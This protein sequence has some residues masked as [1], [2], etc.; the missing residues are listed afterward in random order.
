MKFVPWR[1]IS[2][3]TSLG[4][5]ILAG[6]AVGGI[7]F[8]LAG[9]LPVTAGRVRLAGIKAPVEIRR[10]ADAVPHIRALS[11]A[12]ALLGLGYVHAQDRLW[13]MEYQRRIG[14]GRLAEVLGEAALETDQFLRTVGTGRA[15]KSAWQRTRP[16][17]RRL[18][19]AYTAGINAFIASHRGRRL[20]VEFA[21]LGFEPEPWKPE[22][23]V[24]WSKIMAL[25]LGGNW[26]DEILRSELAARLG[27]ERAARLLPAYTADG[28]VILP[29]KGQNAAAAVPS[30]VPA[31]LRPGSLL[32]LSDKI[33]TLLGGESLAVG[34][35]NWVVAGSRTASGKPMLASDPHLGHQIPSVWYLAHVEGGNFNAIGATL[36]GL[37][38][39]PIGHNGRIAWGV[40]NLEADV[41]D[42]F[43]EQ[44][45]A[46]ERHYRAKGRWQPLTVISEV[47]KVKGKPA[48]PIAVRITRHGPLISD[49]VK[50]TAQ[51][52]A[53]RWAALDLEDHTIE[54][55]LGVN[56]ASDWRDFTRA[57]ANFH[58]PM[59]NFVYAD[60]AGNIGYYAAGAVP[61]RSSGDGTAPVP[62]QDDRY[63]WRGYVPF[64]ALP[65]TYNPPRGFVATA[66]NRAVSGGYPYVLSTNWAPP[67]RA[68]RIVERLAAARKL[69]AR[70]MADLQGDVQ[71]TYVRRLLPLLL[72]VEGS[73]ARSRQAIAFLRGWDGRLTGDSAAAAIFWA[74][75][76]RIPEALF[77]DELGADL[78]GKYLR[79]GGMLGKV[80]PGALAGEGG[81]CDDAATR[82][83]EDCREILK[84]ALAAGLDDMTR[85]QGS[86][87]PAD[88]RWDR[89]HRAVF[90]H[91]P[92]DKI[93]TLKPLFS[94]SIGNGGDSFTVN[95]APVNRKEPYN[96]FVGVSY[97]QI[98]DFGALE[99]SR[100]I[101][102]T[103]QSG[104]FL[105]GDYAAY[106]E[107]WRRL[108]YVPMRFGRRAVEAAT[109]ATL[110][111]EP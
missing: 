23:V 60:R 100:F 79:L 108:E 19:E 96:Q 110:V 66:N 88:W 86:D 21:L 50:G 43:I 97:R 91:A 73:D 55:Y 42:L 3:R 32:A 41:Q 28:P 7:Y 93:E 17:T 111:L 6:A 68:E 33:H 4:L 90:A 94:R 45:D 24:V 54:A 49:A 57:L 101:H 16:A 53:L 36:P 84:R 71:S 78:A 38:G 30:P 63:A 83:P 1:K 59:Q 52:L 44:L 65:H 80:L 82:P 31:A 103:G 29:G 62:G 26:S 72:R 75:H 92:F 58:A 105:S 56:T 51:P 104:H 69:T 89:V 40:T 74:W 18:I 39:F 64:G 85:R 102:T 61:V 95:V 99:A 9:G 22:D 47:I 81:W 2:L 46:G 14:H 27:P 15:A 34:S 10:D 109:R 37:P 70:D 87:D 13:Q 106:L 5:L 11:E 48:V 98:V 107:R 76:Q 20:P 67:Y 35:N 8:W 12:D 25:N 77:A